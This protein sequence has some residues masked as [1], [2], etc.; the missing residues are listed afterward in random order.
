[1]QKRGLLHLNDGTRNR[2]LYRVLVV[3]IA[4]CKQQNMPRRMRDHAVRGFDIKILRHKAGWSVLT[5]ECYQPAKCYNI[6]SR[7]G[8]TCLHDQ[9]IEKWHAEW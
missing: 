4:T 6:D 3:D 2:Q 9:V 8:I 7:L 1:M 5:S